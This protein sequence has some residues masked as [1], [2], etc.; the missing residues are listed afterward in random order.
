MSHTYSV[1]H[2]SKCGGKL[3]TGTV[4]GSVEFSVVGLGKGDFSM[5]LQT[6]PSEEDLKREAARR[7]LVKQKKEKKDNKST[8]VEKLGHAL[9]HLSVSKQDENSSSSSLPHMR[10]VMSELTPLE[11]SLVQVCKV[12]QH[13]FMGFLDGLNAELIDSSGAFNSD[14]LGEQ[15][16]KLP[17]YNKRDYDDM[18]VW[19]AAVDKCQGESHARLLYNMAC[20]ITR[21][22][23]VQNSTLYNSERRTG[24]VL[25]YTHFDSHT[26]SSQYEHGPGLVEVNMYADVSRPATVT[27]VDRDSFRGEHV[28]HL[29]IPNKTAKQIAF[30]LGHSG[31]RE[32]KDSAFNFE[33]GIPDLGVKNVS[34]TDKVEPDQVLDYFVQDTLALDLSRY[35]IA[36]MTAALQVYIKSMRLEAEYLVVCEVM[37]L[38]GFF[39][40]PDTREGTWWSR[41]RVQVCLP[42]FFSLR[43]A[44]PMMVEGSPYTIEK[45][46]AHTTSISQ[47]NSYRSMIDYAVMN[48]R[49]M[50]GV[51]EKVRRVAEG[52]DSFG[53]DSA[54]HDVPYE[55]LSVFESTELESGLVPGYGVNYNAEEIARAY[56][57]GDV[58]YYYYETDPDSYAAHMK[59]NDVLPAHKGELCAGNTTSVPPPTSLVPLYG[60]CPAELL[61]YQYMNG[62]R[63]EAFDQSKGAAEYFSYQEMM[64]VANF[65][66]LNRTDSTWQEVQRGCDTE[67]FT[68][69]MS[70]V[71]HAPF[72]YD[73]PMVQYLNT[74]T[75]K[76]DPESRSCGPGYQS[77]CTYGL[78]VA[79]RALW[80]G[81]KSYRRFT[82]SYRGVRANRRSRPLEFKVAGSATYHKFVGGA[83]LTSPEQDHLGESNFHKVQKAAPAVGPSTIVHN[84]ASTQDTGDQHAAE[85]SQDLPEQTPPVEEGGSGKQ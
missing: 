82:V 44:H 67:V 63:I 19:L 43:S 7:E 28:S 47:Q 75:R 62:G 68:G 15:L 85:I 22:Q 31:K 48:Y 37:N 30:V 58:K 59:D 83:P 65:L 14:L 4:D 25:G 45:I 72:Y 80:S 76:R 71:T 32:V 39:P 73:D 18:Q 24:S 21:A 50:L 70:K 29:H 23:L 51:Y 17:G 33:F 16:R 55:Y 74:S 3:Y 40:L 81:V 84:T 54:A 38:S 6:R 57:D 34:Y 1:E 41:F 2:E 64:L 13:R 61:A 79:Y 8:R 66:R 56:A 11:P 46:G 27:V 26:I 52:I 5:Q 35:S 53:P 49:I 36:E 78:Q 60:A 69:A 12:S 20:S 77:I 10:A 9:K 42:E